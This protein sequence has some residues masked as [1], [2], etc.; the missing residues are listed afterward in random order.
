ML[1]NGYVTHDEMMASLAPER[2]EKIIAKAR[3]LMMEMQLQEL[4][5]KQEMTQKQLAEA[6]GVKQ[7]TVNRF[8]A[9]GPEIKISTLKRYVE[10]LGGSLE[11]SVRLP[12]GATR[13][14]I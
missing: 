1:P 4:R 5:T 13:L 3:Q 6:M 10:A 7:S 14:M 8:E 2:R 12:S 9:R 11:M